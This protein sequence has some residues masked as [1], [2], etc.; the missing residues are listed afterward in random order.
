MFAN[1]SVD[2]IAI[3]PKGE[4]WVFVNQRC[5]SIRKGTDRRVIAAEN[6]NCI[7]TADKVEIFS[8]VIGDEVVCVFRIDDRVRDSELGGFVGGE[9]ENVKECISR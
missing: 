7:G 6:G 2:R 5:F 3:V 1:F 8:A 4:G 9:G